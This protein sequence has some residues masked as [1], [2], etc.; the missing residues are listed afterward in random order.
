[1]IGHGAREARPEAEDLVEIS[2]QT[3]TPMTLRTADEIARFFDGFDLVEPGLVW[4]PL[5][6]PDGPAPEDPQRSGN[7]AG[8]GVRG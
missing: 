6:R 4:A 7:L 1:M 8:V 5:W 3:T 2:R